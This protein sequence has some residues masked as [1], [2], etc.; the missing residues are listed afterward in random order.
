MLDYV[1]QYPNFSY[2]KIDNNF[3]LK[4]NKD[5]NQFISTKEIEE[6]EYNFDFNCSELDKLIEENNKEIISLIEKKYIE[7]IQT[8][9]ACLI[10][11]T[12]HI[13]GKI[14]II[15]IKG[16]PKKIY[17]YS[18]TKKDQIFNKNN[19]NRGIFP[20]PIKDTN[21][22]L[23]IELKDIKLI[24]RRIFFYKKSGIEIYTNSK[25]YF[26]NFFENGEYISE[27]IINLLVY[28]AQNNLYPIN[29]NGNII[30]FSKI[31]F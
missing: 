5:N 14:F 3:Y 9:D 30:G 6:F 12:H 23:C 11:R 22:K 2:F 27:I 29:I 25:S 7:N 24:I 20:C 1:N 17:F 4:E 8:Y 31:F 18:C 16:L 15:T 28:Y 19:Y 10:K 21:R 26:F 13:K